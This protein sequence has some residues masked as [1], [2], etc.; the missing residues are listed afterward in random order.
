M[1]LIDTHS[2]LYGPEFDEDHEEALAGLPEPASGGCC[3]RPSTPRATT[4][5][6]TSAA[7]IRNGACR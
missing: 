2:H 4:G 3:S 7:C 1:N 5:S 6:S